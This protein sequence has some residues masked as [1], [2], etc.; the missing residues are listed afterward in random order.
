[1]SDKFKVQSKQELPNLARFFKEVEYWVDFY[2][3][4]GSSGH[5]PS[6][7]SGSGLDFDDLVSF[8]AHP[9]SNQIDYLATYRTLSPIP[10]VRI[11]RETSRVN[12]VMIGDL[13]RSMIFGSREPKTWLLAKLAVLFNYTAY[14]FG[15]KFGFY[16]YDDTVVPDLV[17]PLQR[18]KTYGLEIGNALLNFQPFNDSACGVLEIPLLLPY[19]KSLII[20]ASDFHWPSDTI[21]EVLNSLSR[22][23]QIIPFVFRDTIEDNWPEKFF[24]LIDFKNIEGREHQS[25]L[26]SG[27]TARQFNEAIWEEKKN[28]GKIFQKFDLLPIY[29]S[30]IDEK[31]IS[32]ELERGRR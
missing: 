30:E 12:V 25:L 29:I 10:L 26:M 17:F 2:P 13:S 7:E 21:E 3:I 19:K 23:H 31:K 5:W 24:G 8:L 9:I 6:K 11:F 1:M 32:E 27:K 18:L 4:S 20:L 15:D 16:G 28:L 14:R 22:R